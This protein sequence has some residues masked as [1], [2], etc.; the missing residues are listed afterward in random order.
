MDSLLNVLLTAGVL[1][2]IAEAIISGRRAEAD[3]KRELHG[4]LRLVLLEIKDNNR[5]AAIMLRRP[6]LIT[7]SPTEFFT[8]DAW[9]E[10]RIRLAQLLPSESHFDALSVYYLNN[11]IARS[12]AQRAADLGSDTGDPGK[13][14]GAVLTELIEQ[15]ERAGTELEEVILQYVPDAPVQQESLEQLEN[16]MERKGWWQREQ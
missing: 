8:D 13:S 6:D 15:Q 12:G 16:E 2:V 4:L 9:M 11:K 1:S 14:V 10:S 7:Y 3:R 5:S